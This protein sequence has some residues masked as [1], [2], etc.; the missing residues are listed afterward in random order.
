[1]EISMRYAVLGMSL[2]KI[3]KNIYEKYRSMMSRCA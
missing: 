2:C 1:M 3:H